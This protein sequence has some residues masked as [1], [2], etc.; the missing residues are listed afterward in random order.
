MLRHWIGVRHRSR[1]G[2]RHWI[3][4]RDTDHRHVSETLITVVLG[5]CVK[6]GI[7]ACVCEVFAVVVA[8]GRIV[9]EKKRVPGN[10]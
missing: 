4:D 9:I 5:G 8:A 3:G 7:H 10:G 1:I 2:D 6:L